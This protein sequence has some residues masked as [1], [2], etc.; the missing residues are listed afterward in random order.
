MTDMTVSFLFILMIMLAF[1]ASQLNPE[2]S[3][4]RAEFD[5]VATERDRLK[6]ELADANRQIEDL[7]AKVKELEAELAKKE[8]VE[9][10]LK[11]TAA[12][13]M[14]ILEQLRDQL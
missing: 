1:F 11:R 9:E 10:Y 6:S 4:T 2:D 14:R 3:V 5:S 7:L 8:P 13:R 12:V